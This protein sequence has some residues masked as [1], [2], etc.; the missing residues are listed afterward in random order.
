MIKLARIDLE[1]FQHTPILAA[2]K[3]SPSGISIETFKGMRLDGVRLSDPRE[4]SEAMK[5]R[6]VI[7]I[8]SLPIW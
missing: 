4:V 2:L 5:V 8:L 6:N 7:Y 1:A 3:K